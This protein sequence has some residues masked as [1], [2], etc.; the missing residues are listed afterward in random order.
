MGQIPANIARTPNALFSQIS[1][2]NINATNLSLLRINEQLS[3]GLRVNRT[4]DDA[5]AS[6]LITTLDRRLETTERRLGAMNNGRLMLDT[7][8][9]ALGELSDVVLEARTLALANIGVTSD[10]D[11][12]AEQAL[13]V[14]SL[15]DRAQTTLNG[16]I[17][18]LHYFAGETVGLDPIETFFGGFRYA[19]QGDGL[20]TDL[21][22]GVNFPV[23]IG[24]GE[25][26]GAVSA[27]VESVVDLN[28][29]VTRTTPIDALRG[30]AVG[31]LPLG[32]LDVTVDVGGTPTTFSVD[33][34][35]ADTVGD[36]AEILE[37]AIRTNAPGALNGAFPNGIGVAAGGDRL[38]IDV[39]AAGPTIIT[40]SDGPTGST[41][42]ALG[43]SDHAYT[44]GAPADPAASGDLDPRVTD[45]TLFGDMNP[46][47]PLSF[48]DIVFENGGRT[49]SVTLDATM[50]LG[51]FREA[52]ERLDLGVRI[53][54]NDAGD[55]INAVNEVA[56]LRMSIGD[57]G[58]VGA[59][60]RL[61]IKTF[62]ESTL[63]EDLNDGRGVAIADGAVDPVTG[64]PDPTRDIDFEIT[65]ADGVSTFTVDLRPQDM[66]DIG[67]V[68]A[69]INA[70]AATAG[71][72]AAFQASVEPS[73]GGIRLED[74]TA[75]PG[76]VSVSSL[77]G[78][79]ADD[80]GLLDGVATAGPGS[81]LVGED[82]ATVRVD[83]FLTALV[84]LRDALSSNDERGIE[85][86][87]QRLEEAVDQVALARARVG[88]RSQ[89]LDA[90]EARTEDVRLLDQS[91]RSQVRDLDFVEASTR[92]SLLQ[93]QLQ[94]GL[95][96]T[97][98]QSQLSLIN[99]LG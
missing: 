45:A 90:I 78:F 35:Q 4:S 33:L 38:A 20:R 89:Q 82:R 8:D 68:V 12:R 22:A 26:L 34:S 95:T 6:A 17:G 64:L 88:G 70:E 27:R 81:A 25:A 65:L 73:A 43:L 53:D 10:P 86:A 80:L 72:G 52:V 23:T 32:S 74:L 29:N 11:T 36:A 92:F 56:G 19:G 57:S 47:P 97:A 49:G 62:A 39:A 63:I 85:F 48:A 9:S 30:P 24:A 1:T 28:A 60:T 79:A 21:G 94:A 75:S 98:Q 84:E 3:T 83:N 15:I 13:I 91:I 66:V 71:F 93:T 7:V 77:N 31:N 96:A 42:T 14:Q 40:F 99:F 55:G 51:E 46:T 37:S 87:G 61:G 50:S 69:R 58:G 18:G 41:A 54:I 2:R 76:A 44:N 59:A 5:V 16:D 67:T